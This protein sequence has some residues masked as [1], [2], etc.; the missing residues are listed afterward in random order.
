MKR[1]K[2]HMSIPSTSS[3]SDGRG[4]KSWKDGS[5]IQIKKGMGKVKKGSFEHRFER[6][7]YLTQLVDEFSKTTAM[8][9]KQQVLANLANFAYDPYNY[10]F[11]QEIGVVSVF[12]AE[13]SVHRNEL[14]TEY[15]MAGVCNCVADRR[16]RKLTLNL[17]WVES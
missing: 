8:E 2:P 3:T 9:C 1:R 7:R 10:H 11:F 12:L 14:L 5:E 17:K 16:I 4:N 13:L 15:A 6:R